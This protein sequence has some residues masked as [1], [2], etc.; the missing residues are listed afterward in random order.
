MKIR[1]A[2][3]SLQKLSEIGQAI[4]IGRRTLVF[5]GGRVGI[6]ED[7]NEED[8]ADGP[9]GTGGSATG[10]REGAE[11]GPR[12]ASAEGSRIGIIDPEVV[13]LAGLEEL[14]SAYPTTIKEGDHGLWII[15]KSKPLESDGPQV[16]F[17]LAYPYSAKIPPRGWAFW[18]VGDFPKIVGP[19][20]TNFPDA[21]ICAFGLDDGAWE[22]DDGLTA[23]IDLY[24]TWAVRHLYFEHFGRWPGR[25]HGATAL[26]RR[27][28]FLSDEWCGCGSGLRY[29]QCHEESDKLPDDDSAREDHRHILGSDYGPR[30]PPKSVMKFVRSGFEKIPALKD[31]YEYR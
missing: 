11:A 22:R 29:G 31:A 28:E 12:R 7:L 8:R 23:L 27:T 30:R 26:Y 2:D 19:R 16:T 5:D 13:R 14:C 15:T 6:V 4:D 3:N 21:S 25:Q 24:S 10:S 18:K 20:H 17:V 9:E 1:L